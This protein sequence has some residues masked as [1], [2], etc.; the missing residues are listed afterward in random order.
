M[1]P[2]QAGP[3]EPA[4]PS[5]SPSAVTTATRHQ[6]C[7]VLVG[8]AGELAWM[9]E[10]LARVRRHAPV[11]LLIGGEAGAG[12]SRLVG[13]FA[14]VVSSAATG[15]GEA[16]AGG[17]PV[18]VLT[19]E[20]L[21]LGAVGVPFAPFSAILTQAVTGLGTSGLVTWPP[22][23]TSGE[24]TRLLPGGPGR[25][26]AGSRAGTNLA[27]ESDPAAAT[28]RL[29][30][31]ALSLLRGLAERGPVVLVI[32]DAQWADESSRALLSFL[33]AHQQ[34]L[35]GV[36]II[37]TYRSD[38]LHRAH[39]LRPLLGGLGRLGWV[40]RI[41]L[42]GLSRDE[43]GELI[44]RIL[45][46]TPDS[47]VIDAVYR[48]TQGNPL[49][50]EELLRADGQQ[51]RKAPRRSGSLRDLFL[52]RIRR[53]P[54]ETQ[55]VLRAASVGGQRTGLALLAAVTGV[56]ADA[57][58][59]ALRPAEESGLLLAG[60]DGCAFRHALVC[61]AIHQDL[62]PGEHTRLHY[63]FAA[64]LQADPGLMPPG[65]AAIEQAQHWH[66]AHHPVWALSSAWQAA[67][68]AGRVLAHPEQLAMLARV[69]ELWRCVPDA[70]RRTG[71]DHAGV[72]EKAASAAEAAGEAELATAFV[73]AALD[74]VDG[75]SVP[76]RAARLLARRDRLEGHA[77]QSL[78]PG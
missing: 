25:G 22:G 8:R 41:E 62:L 67:A 76:G 2:T 63:Q 45:G 48:R 37:V 68:E 23:S 4:G 54:E 3:S 36:L 39:P 74:E 27:G 13:E 17:E 32:E 14:A 55:D 35:G 64:A 46:G 66:H 12:K 1:N 53:L 52:A 21:E 9:R 19:G 59:A 42:P 61:E 56:S 20:C 40:R 51:G 65:R 16:P 28:A 49:F 78:P 26:L 70:P 31:Q 72:L 34:A 69:L 11:T 47:S 5:G 38:E 30:E 6:V 58:T 71:T 15:P 10:A 57:L 7:P 29:F 60:A 24:L 33:T 75:H 50:V 43:S 44:G 77:H 18:R 73:T